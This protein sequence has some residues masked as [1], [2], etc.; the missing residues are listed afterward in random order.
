MFC[1]CG[2]YNESV[3]DTTMLSPHEV[4]GIPCTASMADVKRA[5][6][7]MVLKHH[8]DKSD[9]TENLE[10]FLRLQDAYKLLSDP[11][12]YEVWSLI[13]DRIEGSV[14]ETL[15]RAAEDVILMHVRPECYRYISI[16][17]RDGKLFIN[18]PCDAFI[19]EAPDS[20]RSVAERTENTSCGGAEPVN[21]VL[22]SMP[23]CSG[24]EQ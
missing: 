4:L 6:R 8:P 5:Y 17:V 3:Q 15:R 7:R 16:D 14:I 18:V 11:G 2:D 10:T 20:N 13:N 12:R 23:P 21:I 22:V 24:A 19:S 1:C 9:A